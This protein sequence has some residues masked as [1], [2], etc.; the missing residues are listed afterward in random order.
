MPESKKQSKRK[1]GEGNCE[2]EKNEGGVVDKTSSSRVCG[3]GSGQPGPEVRERVSKAVEVRADG[4][5][6]T[7]TVEPGRKLQ[8]PGQLRE[9][10]LSGKIDLDA[11]ADELI[12]GMKAV[13]TWVTK[14]GDVIERPDPKVRL[15]YLKFV[16]EHVEGM[17]VKR[18]EIISRKITSDEDLQAQIAKSPAFRRQVQKLIDAAEKK[19]EKVAG[20]PGAKVREPGSSKG[21]AKS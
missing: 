12:A 21:G 7:R 4:R 9:A 17:P 1:T 20:E 3:D 15:D 10:M 2:G 11:F 8:V 5:Q 14:N 19:A 6:V 13:Q 18:Q 16:T